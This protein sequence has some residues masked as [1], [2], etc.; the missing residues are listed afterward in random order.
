MENITDK[1]FVMLAAALGGVKAVFEQYI[2]S[3]WQFAYFLIIIIAVDTVLGTYKAWKSKSLESRAYG[4]LFEKVLL[5]G[6][7]LIMTNVLV[8]FTISGVA[9]GMFNWLDDALYCG[10]MVR[11]AISIVENVAEIKPDLLP[12]WVVRRLKKFDESGKLK[13]LMNGDENQ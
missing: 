13:D 9:T 10:I 2:F 7:V 11:E 3:D 1:Q 4:R 6:C 12:A 8:T 5:Y